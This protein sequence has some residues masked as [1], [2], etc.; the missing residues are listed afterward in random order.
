MLPTPQH[1]L[2][3]VEGRT[4]MD[5]H[6]LAKWFDDLKGLLEPAYVAAEKP[7]QQSG[8]GLRDPQRTFERWRAQ[9]KP[10]ADAVT[11][12][13]T[14]LDIGCANG[15]LLECVVQWVGERGL[16]V[17]PYGLDLSDKLV[18]MAKTRL[19]QFADNLFVG[20]GWD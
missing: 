14:F 1:S 6:D 15:F 17:T 5:Q 2:N 9:R 19:P 7:W 20:N 11:S 18:A 10:V 12:S 3:S 8:F 4:G 13:G 16:A